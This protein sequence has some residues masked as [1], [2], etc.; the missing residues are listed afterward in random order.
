M[1]Y[2]RYIVS[3]IFILITL[4]SCKISDPNPADSLPSWND[5]LSKDAIIGFVNEITDE[6][7]PNF[8][9]A[10]ERIATFDN[11]GTL[12]S[13]QPAYFQLFF[14]IDRVKALAPE[15]PEWKIKQ[16]FKAVLEN[17]I[18]QNEPIELQIIFQPQSF[19]EKTLGFE[20]KF[21]SVFKF[22]LHFCGYRLQG[23]P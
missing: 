15:H 11:D 1:K 12:W 16:P 5:G 6:N 22:E 19:Q 21:S 10:A 8:V 9:P 17:D 2:R 3:A 13:E 14:A 4:N 18:L 7:S 20:V 23:V